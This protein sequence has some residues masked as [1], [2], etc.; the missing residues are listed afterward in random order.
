M[1]SLSAEIAACE[2]FRLDPHV[3]PSIEMLRAYVA[4]V[5]LK[6]EQLEHVAR[7]MSAT[8]S[9]LRIRHDQLDIRLGPLPRA[10][11]AS[12]I[13]TMSMDVPRNEPTLKL[14]E[15]FRKLL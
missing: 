14:V 15:S 11:E 4:A 8:R 3:P 5:P 7:R 6:S 10:S 1:F 13:G 2:R 12:A 9:V